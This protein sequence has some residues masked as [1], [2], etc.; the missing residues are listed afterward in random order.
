MSP[1]ERRAADALK[2]V[3]SLL[4]ASRGE[5]P[6]GGRPLANLAAAMAIE[7]SGADRGALLIASGQG[8]AATLA[9]DRT[10]EK[11]PAAGGLTQIPA[12]LEAA[13]T[14]RLVE[15]GRQV[16]A[17]ISVRGQL[18]GVLYLERDSEPLEAGTAELAAAVADRISTLIFSADLVEEVSRRTGEMETLESLSAALAAGRLSGENLDRALEAV[19]SY[20]SSPDVLLGLIDRRGGVRTLRV[21]GREPES[22]R[23]LGDR[24]VD[25]LTRG[26]ARPHPELL[27]EPCL[28]E[29]LWA[30]LMPSERPERARRPA[31]FLAARRPAG[32]TYSKE[33]RTFFGALAHLLSGALARLDYFH[34][35]SE[36]PLTETGSRLALQIRLAEA[37]AATL[38]AG[39]PFSV[40]LVDVDHFKE[41]NDR[42]G[43]LLGDAV[44]QEV[45]ALLRSR[46]RAQDSVAR[47]GG[48]E[49]VLILPLTESE[50]AAHLAGELRQLAGEREFTDRRL[51][52]SLSMG[53]A[54]FTVE[55]GG[56]SEILRRA[57]E[58][59]YQSKSAGRNRVTISPQIELDR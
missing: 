32:T 15:A 45:A 39:K 44:L 13:S 52:I 6:V 55:A 21:A 47:Y 36:D 18:R 34:R 58:A 2:A 50:E 4:A 28:F 33:D 9:L 30:D 49:F 56:L 17:P 42:H 31:G 8:L 57:D 54:T 20:T 12:V 7:Y 43:H 53:V 11:T 3:D 37:E 10:L 46:L 14:R 23:A 27:G 29:I 48:D 41:I 26:D 16:A 25:G 35:A 40:V 19:V 22:L 38:K 51:S 24:I 1:P 5:Q 59:L